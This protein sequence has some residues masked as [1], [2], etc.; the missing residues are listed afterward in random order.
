MPITLQE[1]HNILTQL[2]RGTQGSG[3]SFRDFNYAA[4]EIIVDFLDAYGREVSI[5]VILNDPVWVVAAQ[6]DSFGFSFAGFTYPEGTEVDLN[7]RITRE[8]EL[9]A[10]WEPN[11]FVD[12]VA[13]VTQKSGN[14]N[15]LTITV[16]EIDSAGRET[17]LTRTFEIRN[18]A[19]DTYQVGPVR[20][21]VDTKGN[22]QIRSIRIVD[23]APVVAV[24]SAFVTSQSGNT[25]LLTVTVN[26][27]Y[28]FGL[29][30]PYT[31]TFTIR[32][33]ASGTYEV[34]PY[35]V[36]VETSGNTQ[37]RTIRIV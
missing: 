24:P 3:A 19:A 23:F 16:T 37:I 8:T 9:V 28:A 30:V 34:G 32:N 4:R 17:P 1:R 11:T 14:M 12:P 31:E 5:P 15:D 22:T 18:N 10:V 25:N 35:S 7:S 20:V 29:V 6:T 2:G 33:N 26:V 36:F 21:F 13:V 27:N